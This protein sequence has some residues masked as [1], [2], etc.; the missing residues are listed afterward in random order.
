MISLRQRQKR[1]HRQ[2]RHT[3]ILR[4]LAGRDGAEKPLGEVAVFRW[5][6]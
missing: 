3:S 4:Y 6:Q 1:S 2:W 5:L